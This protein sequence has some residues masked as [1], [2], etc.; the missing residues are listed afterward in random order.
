MEVK[1]EELKVL[2]KEVLNEG[3]SVD[4]KQHKVHHEFIQMQIE[5]YEKNALLWTKFKQSIVGT[6][7]TGLVAGLA[8]V[9]KLVLDNWHRGG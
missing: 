3:R 2:L 1:R 9:G 8:W 6:L 7:A 5:R 4:D